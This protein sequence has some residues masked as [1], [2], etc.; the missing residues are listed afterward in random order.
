MPAES[1]WDKVKCGLICGVIAAVLVGVSL[2][3]DARNQKSIVENHQ[4]VIWEEQ[5]KLLGAL[6][7]SIHNERELVYQVIPERNLELMHVERKL[8]EV[9]KQL[10]P[11]K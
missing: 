4:K 7:D 1:N 3:L 10:F 8:A 6:I 2:K 11:R 5:H 9:R